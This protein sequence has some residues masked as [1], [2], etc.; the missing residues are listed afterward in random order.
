MLRRVK[1]SLITMSTVMAGLLLTTFVVLGGCDNTENSKNKPQASGPAFAD[2]PSQTNKKTYLF[3][4]HPLHNPDRLFEVYQPLVNYLN[5]RLDQAQLKLEA[6]TSYDA[7]EQK[8]YSGHYQFALPNPYQTITSF[9]HGYHAFGKMGD[10]QNF[11][12][13]I[14]VRKDSPIEKVEDLRGKAISYPAPTALA[15]SMLPQWLMYQ[16]GLNITTD[17]DNRYVGSQ[18]SSIMNV[19]LGLTQAGCTWP[20]PW[21]AFI[22]THPDLADKLQIKWKTE[23]LPNNGLVARDDVPADVVKQVGELIFSLHTTEQGRA[24][25]APME[26]SRFEA[27][28]NDT[29]APVNAFLERF[30]Q[31]V[32]PLEPSR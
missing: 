28:T 11:Y 12:G 18:E 3:G 13:I 17:I 24:I 21:Q 14:L 32:R 22:Q 1:G 15:A 27:A 20:P 31:E 26:L 16:H 6:S 2:K 29:Y 5:H 25:L 19:A 8:L 10:D 9:S 7:Y 4:V 30:K 23:T